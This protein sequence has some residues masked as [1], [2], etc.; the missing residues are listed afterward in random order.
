MCFTAAVGEGHDAPYKLDVFESSLFVMMKL[1]HDVYK[2]H[3]FGPLEEDTGVTAGSKSL[4]VKG[5]VRIGDIV[6]VQQYRQKDMT[7]DGTSMS[8]FRQIQNIPLSPC[9]RSP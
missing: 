4:I 3:K 8:I 5:S 6:V 2:L 1:S 9:S 7:A